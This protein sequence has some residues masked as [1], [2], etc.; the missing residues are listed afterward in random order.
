MTIV[1]MQ[2]EIVYTMNMKTKKLKSSKWG[3]CYEIL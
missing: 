2:D 3:N 1:D